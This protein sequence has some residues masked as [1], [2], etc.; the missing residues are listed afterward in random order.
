MSKNKFKNKQ[1]VN[2]FIVSFFQVT[3]FCVSQHRS[4][5]EPLSDLHGSLGKHRLRNAALGQY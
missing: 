1:D 5:T 4:F 2:I 3:F